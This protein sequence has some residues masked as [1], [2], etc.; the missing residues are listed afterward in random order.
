MAGEQSKIFTY[1]YVSLYTT[2]TDTDDLLPF[3]IQEN[4]ISV[5]DL[6]VIDAGTTTREKVK[7]LLLQIASPLEAGDAT[8]FHKMLTI[9]KEHGNQNTKDL[10]IKMSSEM[11]FSDNMQHEG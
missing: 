5:S 10:A 1:H 6:A 9:M 11:T 4:I 8:G 2:V 7:K 3:L